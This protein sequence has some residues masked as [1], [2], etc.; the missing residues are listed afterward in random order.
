MVLTACDLSSDS[1]ESTV[2]G[3]VLVYFFAAAFNPLLVKQ[4]SVLIIVFTIVIRTVLCPLPVSNEF[5][6]QDVRNSTLLGWNSE[7][8]PGK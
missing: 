8:H 3:N 2:V 5:N 4:V 1:R 7:P 6:P